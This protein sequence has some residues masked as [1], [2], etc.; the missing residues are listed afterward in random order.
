MYLVIGKP[1]CIYCKNAIILL[2]FKN[3]NYMFLDLNTNPNH[4]YKKYIPKNYKYVPQII[5]INK[6][7]IKFIGGYSDLKGKLQVG[8]KNKNKTK[9]KSKIGA[10]SPKYSLTKNKNGTCYDKDGL[11][12][13][14]KTYNLTNNGNGN[15][16]GINYKKTESVN[17][18]WNKLNEKLSAKCSDESCWSEV[19]NNMKLLKKH[20]IPKKPNSWKNSPNEWL[21]TIDIENVLKQYEH[22][23]N[24]F[25]F[26]GCVPVDFDTRLMPGICVDKTLCSFEL[27][28]YL[29]KQ[30]T[31]M[32]AVYNIDKH[33]EPGSHWVASYID[34]NKKEVYYFDS[35]GLKPPPEIDNFNNKVVAQAKELG[36][37]YDY[38]INN[39][40]HQ[41]KDTEC[42]IYCINFIINM[43]ETG[44]FNTHVNNYMPDDLMA[45]NR[46]KYF[47]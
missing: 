2:N 41:K 9:K 17:S 11:I 47:S 3:Q 10:C 16:N 26:L 27:K 24:D 5:N 4:K 36:Y 20:F 37:T 18:L 1:D 44:D 30:I 15:G 31:R 23:H 35:V 14:I 39:N 46:D 29:N 45:K 38:K 21:S 34:H 43:L 8:G 32:G 12:E 6:N 22:K 42:G 40:G 19:T 25:K 7:K 33:D 13:L 28:D